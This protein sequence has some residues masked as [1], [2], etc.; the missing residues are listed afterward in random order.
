MIKKNIKNHN[1][2]EKDN[3]VLTGGNDNFIVIN[4]GTSNIQLNNV[5]TAVI[6]E[7]RQPERFLLSIYINGETKRFYVNNQNPVSYVYND[8][9]L[10]NW[11]PLKLEIMEALHGPFNPDFFYNW[12]N[13]NNECGL[14]LTLEKID[15]TGIVI[16]CQNFHD[17][18]LSEINYEVVFDRPMGNM[19]IKIYFSNVVTIL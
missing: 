14:F 16:G 11:L 2:I 7:R 6:Q 12:F 5:N 1:F 19:K 13:Q 4:N 8:N 10:K 17:C 9:F 15:P 18:F 3:L